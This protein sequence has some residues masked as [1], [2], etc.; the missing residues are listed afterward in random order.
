MSFRQCEQFTGFNTKNYNLFQLK[1]Q[2]NL[3]ARLGHCLTILD[4]GSIFPFEKSPLG[5]HIKNSLGLSIE[6][7]HIIYG[8]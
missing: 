1:I 2:L 7:F 4:L 6:Y 3:L 5:C 8:P